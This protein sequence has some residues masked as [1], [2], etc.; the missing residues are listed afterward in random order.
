VI[1][2]YAY[3]LFQIAVGAIAAY[4]VRPDFIPRG[5]FTFPDNPAAG[6]ALRIGAFLVVF[7]VLQAF[8][9]RQS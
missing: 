9:P 4:L 5:V 7:L 6:V 3:R 8:V 2:Y 1:R